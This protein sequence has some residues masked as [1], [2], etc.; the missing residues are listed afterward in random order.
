MRASPSAK[1]RDRHGSPRAQI[2]VVAETAYPEV[3]AGSRVRVVEMGRHLE[4]HGVRVDC[5]PNL[6]SHEYELIAAPGL[7]P[8]KPVALTRGLVRS[9]RAR[10]GVSD[11]LT[12]VHRLRSLV[13][14]PGD[15]RPLDI[16]DFD[17]ALY[18]GA[19]GSHHLRL[20]M[21][22]REA[23][24]CLRYMRSAR[25]VL[26][27]N[28]VLADAARDHAER[29]EVVPSCVDPT[30]QPM[31]EHREVETLSLGWIGSV[32]T[33]RYLTPVLE[34][35][36][37]LY[38][39]GWPIR[40]V[41]MGASV[42]LREPWLEHRPWSLD[43]ERRMLTEVDVGLMPLPDDAW[44]RGKCGY[45]LLRYFSAGLPTIAS[46]VGINAEL[47]ERG[48]GM[49]ATSPT[50]WSRAIAALSADASARADIAKQARAFVEREFSY[51]VWAP[52][53]AGLIRELS[54]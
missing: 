6:T 22:K 15:D 54:T 13:P 52:R 5:R 39:Q 44:A 37:G 25:V 28:R 3:T 48:G 29:I 24:R 8:T 2:S 27:G 43:A 50:E 18:L 38:Q 40:L 33:S 45:K 49:S 19:A 34:L 31:R 42:P 17:D 41:L 35:V 32:T 47:I 51:Q 12:L 4:H 23:S 30:L 9:T 16:Y 53:V 7:S 26:A 46:P 10:N 36:G 11:S 21:V 1:G 14:S 20:G